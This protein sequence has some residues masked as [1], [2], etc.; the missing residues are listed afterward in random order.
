MDYIPKLTHIALRVSNIDQSAEF[1]ETYTGL[2]L[3]SMRE[4]KEGRVAWLGNPDVKEQF[5]IVLLEFPFQKSEQPRFDHIGLDVP[6]RACV[7]EINQ[8]AKDDGILFMEAKDHGKITGYFCIVTDPDGNL[9]EF[10]Y[11]QKIDEAL[12][13]K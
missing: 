4:E 5:I 2:K 12:R 6:S 8:K 10:S 9:V 3:I 11:G 1:Y 7:D 13:P